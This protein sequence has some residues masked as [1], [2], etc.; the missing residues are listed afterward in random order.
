MPACGYRSSLPSVH[1]S[2]FVLPQWRLLSNWPAMRPV[3][4]SWIRVQDA[5]SIWFDASWAAA[6]YSVSLI[7]ST[8]IWVSIP[9]HL[10]ALTRYADHERPLTP[11]C[12]SNIHSIQPWRRLGG[13]G[14]GGS[15]PAN[16]W[17]NLGQTDRMVCEDRWDCHWSRHWETPRITERLAY[18][19]GAIRSLCN[20]HDRALA[21][22]W[23]RG[24]IWTLDGVCMW[25]GS[26]CQEATKLSRLRRLAAYG[27][28]HCSCSYR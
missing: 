8:H 5:C 18:A 17:T 23:K 15:G 27:S 19:C 12:D 25:R 2:L 28:R 24:L 10:A 21:T 4:L 26:L 3:S 13:A 1:V 11:G 22:H 7:D 6:E 20:H 9:K 16:Q 14:K